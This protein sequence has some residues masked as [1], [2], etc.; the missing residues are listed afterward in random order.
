MTEKIGNHYDAVVIGSGH[1]GLI[2]AAY[3]GKAGKSVLVLEKNDT[4][5]GATASQRVFPDY[6]ALLSRYSY[7]VSLLPKKLID[8][9]DLGF[10]TRRRTTASFTPWLDSESQ[11]R[12]LVL[13]NVDESLSRD[14]MLEMT[15][16]HS[17]WDRY[18]EF[19]SLESAIAKVIWPTMLQPLRTRASF[20]AE[21]R[22]AAQRRAWRLFI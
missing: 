9:L 6:D 10:Q 3:L 4:F 1:N 19:L 11:Q 17:A 18:Q 21:L 14:S 20:E 13:S 8:D 22:T 7:L 2:A 5:G 15:G 16:T 12:G